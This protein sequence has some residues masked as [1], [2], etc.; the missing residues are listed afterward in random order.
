[1]DLHVSQVS[2]GCRHLQHL[3]FLPHHIRNCVKCQDMTDQY[4]A[5]NSTSLYG[6]YLSRAWC[7]L[8]YILLTKP[9]IRVC[10]WSR[11]GTH[12]WILTSKLHCSFDMSPTESPSASTTVWNN[13]SLT[14]MC[15]CCLF[16]SFIHSI[17]QE[18]VYCLFWVMELALR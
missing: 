15:L 1:M 8:R 17:Y 12:D 6:G 9:V 2:R 18:N 4:E 7:W 14:W 16:H 10:V 5:H 11:F 3:L 13:K